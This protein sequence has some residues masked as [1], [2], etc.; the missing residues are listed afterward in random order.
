[1]S[2]ANLGGHRA[3]PVHVYVATGAREL[4]MAFKSD[5]DRAPCSILMSEPEARLLLLVLSAQ[6]EYLARVREVRGEG[7]PA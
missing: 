2:A 7:V 4:V 6:V 5:C 1:M 3:G